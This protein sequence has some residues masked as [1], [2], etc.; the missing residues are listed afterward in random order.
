MSGFEIAGVVL[1]AFPILC[2]ASKDLRR[3]YQDVQ[4][5]WQFEREFED[6][7]QDVWREHMTFLQIV[8]LLLD[9]ITNLTQ[10]ERRALESDPGSMLWRSPHIQSELE[11][12]IQTKYYKWFQHQLAALNDEICALHR[13]LP[14]RK[15]YYV[16]ST[17]LESELYRLKTAF[18]HKKDMHLS[19]IREGNKALYGFLDRASHLSRSSTSISPI[20]NNTILSSIF[21]AQEQAKCVYQCFQRRWTCTCVPVQQHPC[22]ITVEGPYLQFLFVNDSK[23]T[24]VQFGFSKTIDPA[25]D[26]PDP[27]R[28]EEVLI[29]NEQVSLKNRLKNLKKESKGVMQLAASSLTVLS[30][31]QPRNKMLFEGFQKP[32]E[33]LKKKKV[34]FANRATTAVSPSPT[35]IPAPPISRHDTGEEIVSMCLAIKDSNQLPVPSIGF[36][37]SGPELRIILQFQDQPTGSPANQTFESFL[38]STTRRFAR[39][40]L[41]L[42]VLLGILKLGS[43][44]LPQAW[45][46]QSINVVKWEPGKEQQPLVYPYLSHPSIHQTLDAERLTITSTENARASLLSLGILLLELLFGQTLEE[47]AFYADF[48]NKEGEANE[49]TALCAAWKWQKGVEEEFGQKMANAIRLCVTC[50][51]DS[52]DLENSKFVAAVWT[53]VAQPIE[54]F[55]QAYR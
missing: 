43:C 55:L 52:P 30:T 44:W 50:E 20:R 45:S 14:V 17:N 18:S 25:I 6:F 28:S 46:K 15:A 51:F 36:M 2:D 34:A 21:D 13:L 40:Q 8:E 54:E 1:G 39:L 11:Q 16:D 4:T 53:S 31:A 5:W 38:R 9:P 29:L 24:K 7:I 10:D 12:R 26:E 37:D 22:S 32:S 35:G 19:K 49:F 23:T 48:C 47:Q 33:K 3:W 27:P 41:G 42:N